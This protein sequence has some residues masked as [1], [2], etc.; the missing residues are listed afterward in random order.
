M[1]WFVEHSTQT[2]QQTLFPLTLLLQ[3][4]KECASGGQFSAD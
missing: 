4:S 1:V 3:A 2:L